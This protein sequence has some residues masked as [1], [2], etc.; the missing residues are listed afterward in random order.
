[1]SEDEWILDG[2]ESRNS[3]ISLDEFKDLIHYWDNQDYFENT[4][5]GIF[6]TGEVYVGVPLNGKLMLNQVEKS[7]C[8]IERHSFIHINGMININSCDRMLILFKEPGLGSKFNCVRLLHGNGGAVIDVEIDVFGLGFE[9]V[10]GQVPL[11][12]FKK[13]YWDPNEYMTPEAIE[14]LDGW[15]KETETTKVFRNEVGGKT[16]C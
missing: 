11:Y 7:D 16:V 4:F 1:M 5:P 13:F 3:L 2:R 10:D 9:D 8:F 15:F 14:I 12:G 6:T